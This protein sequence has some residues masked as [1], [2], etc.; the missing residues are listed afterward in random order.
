MENQFVV[1]R[2]V[3][4]PV[5]FAVDFCRTLGLSC[6][7]NLY[8][9]YFIWYIWPCSCWGIWLREEEWLSHGWRQLLV[10]KFSNLIFNNRHWSS[11]PIGNDCCCTYLFFFFFFSFLLI[12]KFT[13]ICLKKLNIPRYRLIYVS[14][15]LHTCPYLQLCPS[16][17]DPFLMDK[18]P[19]IGYFCR[20]LRFWSR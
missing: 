14:E 19:T 9:A 6:F 13:P 5:V 12:Q 11:L 2:R 17:K 1:A 7:D 10:S 4:L 8:V 3:L 20:K 18:D 15:K 16:L